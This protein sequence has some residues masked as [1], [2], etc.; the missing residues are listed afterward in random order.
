MLFRSMLSAMAKMFRGWKA[1][2]NRE[3]VKKNKVP[4]PKKM[5]E[6]TQAEWGNLFVRRPN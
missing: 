6:I 5:G 3:F 4:P 1:E 2:M